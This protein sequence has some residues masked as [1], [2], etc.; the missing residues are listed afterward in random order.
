MAYEVDLDVFQGPFDLLLELIARRRLDVTEVDLSDITADYLASL[1]GIDD[2]DLEAATRFLVVAATL[3]E[4][5]AARLL[6]SE[7]LEEEHDLL[8][9]AR[10]LLY[11][12]LLEYRAFR[13]V[14]RSLGSRIERHAGHR[15]REVELD[16][17]FRRLV[18]DVPLEVDVEELARLA[19]RATAPRPDP[20]VDLGHIRRT[21][22]SIRDAAQVVLERVQ[23]VG[24]RA[25]FEEL[26]TGRG[27]TDAV[28]VFLATLEL[29]K[30]GEV[31]LDQA[32]HR[33]ALAVRRREGAG[34]LTVL[35]PSSVIESDDDAAAAGGLDDDAVEVGAAAHDAGR[36]AHVG[37]AADEDRAGAAVPAA[38]GRGGRHGTP[39]ATPAGE[40]A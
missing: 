40:V 29:Y 36:G 18:P 19:S 15:S 10:D 5:K 12:R 28:V 8:A 2:V 26:V 16:S 9:Q 27:R 25:T 17:R 14:A 31:D 3:V 13:D 20:Q 34:D 35:T 33:G 7:D 11:V 4:L 38:V 23:Q 37:V 39:S 30:L 21:F 24:A 22:L 6:P 32:D 1:A